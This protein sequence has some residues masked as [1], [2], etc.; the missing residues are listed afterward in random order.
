MRSPELAMPARMSRLA[1]VFPSRR[2]R[3]ALVALAETGM[4]EL[5]G[6]LTPAEGAEIEAARRLVGA[7][8]SAPH[9][10][11]SRTAPNVADLERAGRGDL[12]TGEA[13][14]SRHAASAVPYHSFAAL[15]G[16]APA[17][18]VPSL[19]ERLAPIGAAPVELPAPRWE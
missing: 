19:R 13:E 18:S 5:A 7:G 10:R 3:D 2:T 14:L 16:W 11:I 12:L 8:G 4:V 17:G 6:P 15:L 1:I 9:P